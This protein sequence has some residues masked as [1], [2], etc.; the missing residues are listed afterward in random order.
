MTTTATAPTNGNATS[1]SGFAAMEV[2]QE[3]VPYEY[4]LRT[5]KGHECLIKVEA[6]GLCFSDIAMIDNLA[7][8]TTYPLV[9]GHEV[10]GQVIAVGPD[11]TG[12]SI[13]DRVGVGWFAGSCLACE[14]CQRGDDNVCD[15]AIGLIVMGP[16]GFSSHVLVD[17]RWAFQLPEGISSVAAGPLM[18]AGVT[19]YA[20]LVNGGMSSGQNIGVVGIGGLGHLAI[21]FASAF[22]NRV[23]AFALND[24]VA[25][26]SLELGAD[27]AI[28]VSANGDIPTPSQKLDIILDA[29]AAPLDWDGYLNLLEVDGCLSIVGMPVEPL[30]FSLSSLLY[31][32]RKITSSPVASRMQVREM[33]KWA[34]FF[35]IEPVVETYAM[36][37]I[38]SA[39]A[40]LRANNVHYR[41]VLVNE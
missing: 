14:Y 41:A 10:V 4:E 36:A 3:L 5:P 9:P 16:G 26:T 31:K 11:A 21:K 39:I 8:A 37:D 6:S 22:G 15:E 13:G 35:G 30:S 27:E 19:V 1:A 24:A 40:D 20:G 33:L 25:Q 38:N 34:D 17:S 32:R 12:V 7:D 23:T 2:R 18:C 28:V 29:A